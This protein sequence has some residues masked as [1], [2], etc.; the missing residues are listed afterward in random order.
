MSVVLFL[1]LGFQTGFRVWSSEFLAEEAAL[2]QHHCMC[3]FLETLLWRVK[4][5]S[6]KI[7]MICLYSGKPGCEGAWQWVLTFLQNQP[8]SYQS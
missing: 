2:P 8:I 3:I 1:L 4:Q 5:C 7:I 6:L